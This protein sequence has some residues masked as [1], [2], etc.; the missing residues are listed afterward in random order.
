MGA[1][2]RILRIAAEVLGVLLVLA[3]L[4][5]VVAVIAVFKH[6]AWQPY[7]SVV[8]SKAADAFYGFEG[9]TRPGFISSIGFGLSCL[10]GVLVIVWRVR[11]KQLMAERIKETL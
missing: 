9:T 8:L 10:V 11:E 4:A 7:F 2:R 3:G 5:T 6:P 1:M